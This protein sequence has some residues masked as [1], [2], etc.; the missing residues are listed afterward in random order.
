KRTQAL[1]SVSDGSVGFT[2]DLAGLG[3]GPYY[4]FVT[5]NRQQVSSAYALSGGAVSDTV[6]PSQVA[7]LIATAVSG[8]QINLAWNAASD[9]VGVAGYRIFRNGVSISTTAT[10]S[11]SDT[12]LSP[13]TAY[14]YSVQAYD[15][16]NNNGTQSQSVSATTLSAQVPTISS[17]SANPTAVNPGQ[18]ATLSWV[19]SGATQLSIDQGIGIVTGSSRSVTP[20]ATA[21]YTLTATNAAGSS[22]SSVQLTV[23]SAPALPVISSFAV[24][25][26]SIIE[27]SSSTLSWSVSGASSVA[28]DQGIGT[29]SSSGTTTVTPGQTTVYKITASNSAGSSIASAQLSV[30]A[31]TIPKDGTLIKDANI[32]TVYVMEYS[33]KRPFS[34]MN[35]FRGLGYKTGSIKT[36]DTSGIVMG[37][38]LTTPSQR[39]VR[40]TNVVSNKTIYFLGKDLRYPFPSK[41]VYFSWGCSF[42][43]VVEANSYDLSMGIGPVISQNTGSVQGAVTFAEGSLVKGSFDTVYLFEGGLLKPFTSEASFLARGYSF[44]RVVSVLDDEL[45]GFRKGNEI[46]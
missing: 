2:A 26:N 22:T 18:S 42:S 6:P 4:L 34:S 43:E 16:A 24:S 7:S 27:G 39:H 37:I 45:G 1:T 29:V 23:N 10:T 46:K 12:G 38:P 13:A 30:N 33:L 44:D 25:P 14:T 35:V 5:N 11:Y 31:P 15:A 28:I 9:N 20:A 17:F 40:G 36:I 19:I 8:S 3:S 32:A 21:T 41:S